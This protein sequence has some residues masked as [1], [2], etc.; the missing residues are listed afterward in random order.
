MASLVLL[1]QNMLGKVVV[2]MFGGG[3]GEGEMGVVV[4]EKRAA[5][6]EIG[7]VKIR[8]EMRVVEVK[9]MTRL[10]PILRNR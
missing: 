5:E 2:E 8:E 9:R 3:R 10:C 6:V 7:W 1:K 4:D